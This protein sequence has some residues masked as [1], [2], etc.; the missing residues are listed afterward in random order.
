MEGLFFAIDPVWWITPIHLSSLSITLSA[1]ILMWL[2]T[3][4]YSKRSSK[5]PPSPLRYNSPLEV[6]TQKLYQ[7]GTPTLR[8]EFMSIDP[9]IGNYAELTLIEIRRYLASTH[10]P[11]HSWAHV[12]AH[13]AKYTTDN[14]LMEII[15]ELE[16]VEYSEQDITI[17][18]KEQINRELVIKLKT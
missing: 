18:E 14:R 11:Y 16:Q 3:F 1:G 8:F 13:I 4:L 7:G 12:P 9:N 5:N 2:T 10:Q 6:R 17:N 15:I